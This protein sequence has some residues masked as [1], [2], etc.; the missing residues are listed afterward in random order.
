LLIIR[1]DVL[2]IVRRLAR[3]ILVG[4]LASFAMQ[5]FVAGQEKS[6]RQ[7]IAEEPSLSIFNAGLATADPSIA[8]A[9]D[10]DASYTV[11]APNDEAFRRLAR[12]LQ[13]RLGDITASPEVMSALLSYH[14][15]PGR[16]TESALYQRSGTI[17]PSL[18]E[19]SF[20]TLT[21][22]NDDQVTFNGVGQ[23][24]RRDIPARNGLL[25]ILDDG[26]VNRF[27]NDALGRALNRVSNEDAVRADNGV[28]LSIARSNPYAP[29]I[30]PCAATPYVRLAH[31]AG[32]EQAMSLYVVHS[33]QT[34][35]LL[36]NLE[37]GRFSA[38]LPLPVNRLRVIV[39]QVGVDPQ[40]APLQLD[41]VIGEGCLQ[42]LVLV[43]TTGGLRLAQV[44]ESSAAP[45]AGQSRVTVVNTL[46]T[47][48]SFKLDGQ[49]RVEN[50]RRGESFTFD[51]SYGV[52][53]PSF[54]FENGEPVS[55][56]RISLWDQ[57]RY[58]IVL[59]GTPFAPLVGASA[60]SQAEAERLFGPR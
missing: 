31:W 47:P 11:I 50:M 44:N 46:P 53:Q 29:P 52:Y 24:L 56:T 13:V 51:T 19:G 7:L 2:V 5:P 1:E 16:F 33:G 41:V 9:L 15:L 45:D 34:T 17:L 59:A 36:D 25:H 23:I 35:R 54:V 8:A 57:S 28:T 49:S 12:S 39:A 14:I 60:L 21:I 27:F 55:M 42:T 58:L 37:S 40:N 22:N 18:S 4:L 3:L 20:V 26:L 30:R 48:V 6:L 43:G 32:G 10:S 38:L